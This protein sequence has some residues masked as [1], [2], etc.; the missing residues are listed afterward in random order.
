M[1]MRKGVTLRIKAGVR[2]TVDE[3]REGSLERHQATHHYSGH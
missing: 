2:F 3:G 1:D